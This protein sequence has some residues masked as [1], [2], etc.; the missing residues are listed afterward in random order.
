MDWDMVNPATTIEKSQ[1]TMLPF[2]AVRRY[3]KSWTATPVRFVQ[4][5]SGMEELPW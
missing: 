3:Q 5:G 2:A 1:G 4:S